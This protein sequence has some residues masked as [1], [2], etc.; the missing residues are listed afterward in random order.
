M[1]VNPTK[2]AG[3]PELHHH[4]KMMP[5]PTQLHADLPLHLSSWSLLSQEQMPFMPFVQ[6]WV[7]MLRTEL[8]TFRSW[9]G[10]VQYLALWWKV[11]AGRVPVCLPILAVQLRNMHCNERQVER[12]TWRCFILTQTFWSIKVS[13]VYSNWQQLSRVSGRGLLYHL[14]PGPFD[15]RLWRLNWGPSA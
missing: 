1:L 11:W 10:M 12:N 8:H 13:T 5:W 14:L 4:T 15:W 6:C 2:G 7:N 9:E 3:S